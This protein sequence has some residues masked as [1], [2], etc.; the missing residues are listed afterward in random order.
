MM[1][2]RKKTFG[3]NMSSGLRCYKFKEP[4]DDFL[5]TYLNK[6]FF[7]ELRRRRLLAIS[8]PNYKMSHVNAIILL[9]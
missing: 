4:S 1:R 2:H 9:F 5:D 6:T 8:Y 7:F 3:K